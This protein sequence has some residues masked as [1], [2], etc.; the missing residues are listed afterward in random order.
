MN[1]GFAPAQRAPSHVS[2]GPFTKNSL[3]WILKLLSHEKPLVV[4]ARSVS[5][6][7]F[8][9]SLD[10]HHNAEV[11]MLSHASTRDGEV[12]SF[13]WHKHRL[14]GLHSIINQRLSTCYMFL[15]TCWPGQAQGSTNPIHKMWETPYDPTNSKKKGR[16]SRLED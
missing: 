1:I 5:D 15:S 16:R 8:R 12:G 7:F 4:P 13:S 9:D 3:V 11:L 10:S 6:Y 14:F 2:L